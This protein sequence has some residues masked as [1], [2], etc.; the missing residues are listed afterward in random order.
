MVT[1]I[2]HRTAE[3]WRKR[4]EALE[5]LEHDKALASY[6]QIAAE[7][8]K[9][10]RETEKEIAAFY[11]RFADK[12]NVTL[13]DAKR[14]L[15]TKELKE[16]RWTLSDYIKYSKQNELDGRWVRKLENASILQRISRLEA[17]KLALQQHVEVA[18]GKT[19]TIVEKL[20]EDVFTDTYYHAGFEIAKGIGVTAAF[21]SV[22]E[23]LIDNVVR[24][25][26]AADGLNF[27]DRIWKQKTQMVNQLHSS[28]TRMLARG[29]AP[30]KAIKEMTKYV[31][32]NYKNKQ[33][34]ARRLVLTES[35]YFSSE[36]QKESF[37]EFGVKKYQIVATL[38]F[39]TSDICQDMD[40]KVFDMKDYQIGVTANP[41][42]P[43]CRTTTVPYFED[44]IDSERAARGLDGKT[45]YV[46]GNINYKE[47]KE[48]YVK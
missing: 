21:A 36:A 29:E 47:W 5:K 18:Y 28:L 10:I 26:W 46:P 27:S 41:F 33:Q 13:A 44:R 45:Y 2:R 42:H 34:A 48:K 6:D 17:V 7:F 40:K 24:K 9:S 4:F 35:S 15:S 25:P 11:A 43:N 20:A 32:D 38:D 14:L 16:L 12:N 19:L 37:N 1:K 3:Y 39:R 31:G 8:Q 30:H 23:K 22:D